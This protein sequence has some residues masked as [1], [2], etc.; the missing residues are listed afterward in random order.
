[1]KNISIA[2]QMQHDL[3]NPDITEITITQDGLESRVFY[4]TASVKIYL[5]P[6]GFRI[7]TLDVKHANGRVM[8]YCALDCG[9]ADHFVHSVQAIVEDDTI[10]LD[11]IHFDKT[12]EVFYPKSIGQQMAL[13]GEGYVI[14]WV[15]IEVEY[16]Q[17][18]TETLLTFVWAEG[19]PL[20]RV[21]QQISFQ[22]TVDI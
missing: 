12:K 6:Q 13:T 20:G 1:M 16:L 21:C 9:P 14:C 7:V 18:G 19:M 11:V 17:L 3:I 22:T 4:E 2:P 5:V 10:S 8:T 15:S